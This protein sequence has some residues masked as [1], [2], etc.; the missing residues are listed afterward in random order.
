M[1]DIGRFEAEMMA[2]FVSS[3]SVMIPSKQRIMKQEKSK[4]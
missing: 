3:K 2:F 1:M 4:G